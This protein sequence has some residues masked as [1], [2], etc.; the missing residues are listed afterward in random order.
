LRQTF[1]DA[2]SDLLAGAC[3]GLGFGLYEGPVSLATRL[4]FYLFM[5]R[6]NRRNGFFRSYCGFNQWHRCYGLRVQ[7]GSPELVPAVAATSA[8]GNRALDFLFMRKPR[9]RKMPEFFA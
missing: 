5:G 7:L 2:L 8:R 6:F 1:A 9:L 4:D 3:A